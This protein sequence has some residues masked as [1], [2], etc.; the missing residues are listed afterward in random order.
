QTKYIASLIRDVAGSK[1]R[2][3]LRSRFLSLM[4]QTVDSTSF[5]ELYRSTYDS[6]MRPI[7]DLSLTLDVIRREAPEHF[8]EA[9]RV[10]APKLERLFHEEM[11][12]LELLLN[13]RAG[14]AELM[15]PVLS[16]NEMDCGFD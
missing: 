6:G 13:Q 16:I 14:S 12:R 10:L 2:G 1:A 11:S 5:E 9:Q 8:N 3:D 15:A 4:L 7:A